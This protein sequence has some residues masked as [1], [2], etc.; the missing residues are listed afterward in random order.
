MARQGICRRRRQL[1][2]QPHRLIPDFVP[3]LGYL[4]DLLLI[5]AGIKLALRMVP[6][7]VM[8][9]CQ[10]R[11]RVQQLA[12]HGKPKSWVGAVLIVVLW[13]ALAVWVVKLFLA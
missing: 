3:I 2:P 4:D 7:E 6:A 8:Q 5:P 11:A 1:R 13:L 9:D 10:E 12:Q